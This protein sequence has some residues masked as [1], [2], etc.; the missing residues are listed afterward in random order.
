MYNMAMKKFLTAIILVLLLAGCAST[1]ESKYDF[2]SDDR[3]PPGKNDDDWVRE[4]QQCR[5]MSGKATGIWGLTFPGMAVNMG[6]A[7][8]KYND[9]LREK[10]WLK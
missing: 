4:E 5:D 6:G 7:N 9:C 2:A 3:Y 10:G 8:A 1:K